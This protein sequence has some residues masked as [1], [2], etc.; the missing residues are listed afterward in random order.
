[1]NQRPQRHSKEELT[2]I[3]ES[4]LSTY[5]RIQVDIMF[6]R[7][8]SGKPKAYK[9]YMLE[10]DKAS[11]K[12]MLL[13]T[14]DYMVQEIGRRS[15]EG[16]DLE[17]SRDAAVQYVEKSHVLHS[18]AVLGSIT[19]QLSQEN[20]L[21][22]DVDFDKL[23]FLVIQL[24]RPGDGEK[25][26]LF[27][28]HIRNAASLKTK[29]ARFSFNGREFRPFTDRILTIGSNAEA[30]LIEDFYYI[31]NRDKF[32]SMFDYKDAFL[33]VVE[34]HTKAIV[35]TNMITN[36]QGFIDQCKNDGRYLP[37]LTKAIL[38][39]GFKNLVEYR[40]KLNRIKK[41]YGLNIELTDDEKIVYSRPEDAP[42]ILNLLMDH[43]VISALTEH[44]MLAKAIEKYEIG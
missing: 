36:A 20:T 28:K 14:L 32:N 3:I 6:V 40:S 15:M 44:R 25:L 27:K 29:T 12:E 42:E 13:G 22:Q 37:R 38:G 23:N 43:Y 21:N 39:K 16:Y 8:M 17:L 4:F 10:C 24:F 18:D 7:K 19:Q 1:M 2:Q 35:D 34:E 9:T 33:N 11:V 5:D 26:L 30:F 41:E 31:L